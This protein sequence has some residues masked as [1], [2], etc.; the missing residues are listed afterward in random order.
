MTRVTLLPEFIELAEGLYIR[1][2]VMAAKKIDTTDMA[3]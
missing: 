1:V 2:F 3:R